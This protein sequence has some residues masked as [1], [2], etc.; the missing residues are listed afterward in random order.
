MIARGM[1]ILGLTGSIGMGK[2]TAAKMLRQMKVPVHCSDEAVHAALGAG[3]AAVKK[4]AA[5]YPAAVKKNRAG[6]AFIDRKALGAAAFHDAR[7]MKKLEAIMHPLTRAAEKDF[8]KNAKAAGKKLVVLDIPLL[9]ETGAEKRVNGVIVVTAPAA[10]QK[11][12]VLARRHMDEKRFK[13]ILEKQMPDAKKR[14]KADIVIDTG[15]GL[16]ATRAALKKIVREL[17]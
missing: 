15:K 16:A 2:S 7:L 5:L 9:F 6:K 1:I 14:K 8:L 12:R 4:V 13:A 17:A 3:G 10:L 11:E